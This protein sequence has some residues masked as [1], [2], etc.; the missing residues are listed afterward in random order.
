MEFTYMPKG[1]LP[2]MLISVICMI[3]LMAAMQVEKR[4]AARKC[5]D[6]E[7]IEAA[8]PEEEKKDEKL[9][10]EVE[11]DIENLEDV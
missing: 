4:L 8:V 5:D 10:E 2:G 6:A 3:V 1:L 11:T 7:M 9:Q